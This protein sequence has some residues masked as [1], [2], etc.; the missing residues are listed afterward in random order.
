MVDIE[1]NEEQVSDLFFHNFLQISDDDNI[2]IHKKQLILNR[3]G[4]I[5]PAINMCVSFEKEQL[6]SLT[7]SAEHVQ[8]LV[9]EHLNLFS[10]QVIFIK[11]SPVE[12]EFRIRFAPNREWQIIVYESR[13][14]IMN[15]IEL[16]NEKPFDI[17]KTPPTIGPYKQLG[18][19]NYYFR[20]VED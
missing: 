15:T 11:G 12:L 1:L 20:W 16:L 10:N 8:K 19:S 7:I 2:E 5:Y 9:C 14:A 17:L 6:N 4:R 3:C 18:N 13:E